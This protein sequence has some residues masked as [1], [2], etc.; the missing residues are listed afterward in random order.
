M[1]VTGTQRSAEDD[2]RQQVESCKNERRTLQRELDEIQRKLAQLENEK[3][4]I[5]NQLENV[6]RDRATFLKKIEMV[7]YYGTKKKLPVLY[8][9]L[10]A[11]NL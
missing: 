7:K 9:Y 3:R 4:V 11:G 10:T 8:I 6:K 2:L 5:V 1:Q